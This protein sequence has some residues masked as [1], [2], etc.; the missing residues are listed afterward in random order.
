MERERK[1]LAACSQFGFVAK[2]TPASLAALGE[3]G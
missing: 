2:E 1:H 3:D